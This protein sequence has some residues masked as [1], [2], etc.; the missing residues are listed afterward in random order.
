MGVF[1]ID[2]NVRKISSGIIRGN[3]YPIACMAWHAPGQPP[4]PLLIKFEGEDGENYNS[5]S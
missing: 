4:R 2:T 5:V 1:G 3:T